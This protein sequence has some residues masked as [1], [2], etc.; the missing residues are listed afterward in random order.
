MRVAA[1]EGEVA[2][3]AASSRRFYDQSA[4]DSEEQ[5]LAAVLLR[6]LTT[7]GTDARRLRHK[8]AKELQLDI[9][10]SKREAVEKAAAAMKAARLAKQQAR[11]TRRM[12]GIISTSSNNST[13]PLTLPTP[14]RM[15]TAAPVTARARD[16]RGNG[17]MSCPSPF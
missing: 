12:A 6:S 5:L 11:T 15:A 14:T 4:I 1:G 7:L 13:T 17:L 2:E 9:E 3:E 16:R 10:Q 8:N